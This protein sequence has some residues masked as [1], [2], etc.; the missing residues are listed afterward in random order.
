MSRSRLA[1]P[2]REVLAEAERCEQPA[3]RDEL[4]SHGHG[5]SP[6]G[7]DEHGG[8]LDDS[9]DDGAQANRTNLLEPTRAIRHCSWPTRARVACHRGSSGSEKSQLVALHPARE[10]ARRPFASPDL[11]DGASHPGN[12]LCCGLLLMRLAG[13]S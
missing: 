12:P 7:T 9:G 8:R 5:S 3:I 6:F 11:G 4:E 2:T 1:K 10:L 13:G